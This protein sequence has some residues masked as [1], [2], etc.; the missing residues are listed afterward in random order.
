MKKILSIIILSLFLFIMTIPIFAGAFTDFENYPSF[1]AGGNPVFNIG[2][3]P[4]DYWVG[5]WDGGNLTEASGIAIEDGKGYDKSKALAIWE[6]GNE[7][8]GVYLFITPDNGILSDHNGSLYLRVWMD[9][10]EIGFRKANFGLTDANY[11]LFT[12]DEENANAD[13]WPFYYQAE[14]SDSWE[15][16]YHG[17]DGCFGD[18]QDSDVAGYKGFFAFP[19]SDFVIRNNTANHDALDANTPAPLDN[20]TGVYLFWDYSDNLGLTGGDK[21]Y[22]DNIEFVSD[23]TL[24]DSIYYVEPETEAPQTESPVSENIIQ[25]ETVSAQTGDINIA[26]IICIPA[27][28]AIILKTIKRKNT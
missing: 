28:F 18:A 7:N 26:A 24:F 1:K 19:V 12:T 9:L 25:T 14:G 23:Y 3:S 21:F 10:S 8:Q 2:E 16:L 22:L 17:G 4:A 11:N 13:S 15:T 5:E 27:I 6:D 20:V